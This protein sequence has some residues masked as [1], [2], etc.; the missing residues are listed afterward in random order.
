MADD[1]G[2][3]LEWKV[4]SSCMGVE[5]V[6]QDFVCVFRTDRRG[7]NICSRILYPA[8]SLSLREEVQIRNID[9]GYLRLLRDPFGVRTRKMLITRL[10][11]HDH[12]T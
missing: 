7:Q 2:C 6:W 4:R 10:N 5:D 12:K 8:S 11:I 1:Y 9:A 3:Y